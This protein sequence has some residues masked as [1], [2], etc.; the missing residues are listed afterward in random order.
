MGA[1][2][3]DNIEIAIAALAA[4]PDL[5]VV[6]RAGDD[7]VIAESRSLFRIGQ[8]R[9]VSALTAHAVTLSLLGRPPRIVSCTASGSSPIPKRTCRPPKHRRTRADAPAPTPYLPSP[10]AA[11]KMIN[12]ESFRRDDCAA[13]L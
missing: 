9:D 6:L 3:L 10:T 4:A 13:W 2:E 8:V 11:P 7:D 5:R 12:G 1:D